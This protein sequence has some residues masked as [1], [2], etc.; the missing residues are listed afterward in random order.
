MADWK[1]VT[2]KAGIVIADARTYLNKRARKVTNPVEIKGLHDWSKRLGKAHVQIINYQP[3]APP[4]PSVVGEYEVVLGKL[5]DFSQQIRGLYKGVGYSHVKGVLTNFHQ[6]LTMLTGPEG[7]GKGPRIGGPGSEP[8]IG[9]G[10]GPRER[11]KR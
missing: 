1:D 5:E 7:P 2:L 6:N 11:F 10:K 4:K 9:P 3:K 8:R